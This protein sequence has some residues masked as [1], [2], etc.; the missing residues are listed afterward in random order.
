MRRL[1]QVKPGGPQAYWDAMRRLTAR[2]GSFT[3]RD[4]AERFA[5][6]SENTTACYV[7][8]CVREGY[9]DVVGELPASTP[10]GRPFKRFAVKVTAPLD[11]PFEKFDRRPQLGGGQQQMWTV[12]RA[13]PSFTSRDLAVHASTDEVTI[14]AETARVYCWRLRKAGYLL[15]LGRT[16]RWLVL[17]L[18]PGMNV[19]PK[20]PAI[21]DAGSVVADRNRSARR[22]SAP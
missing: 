1:H 18:K 11:A 19:G 6:R 9:L 4:L 21:I 2:A 10:A 15:E 22:R 16:G 14:S 13:L 12:M 17:R 20:P 7:H 5:D 8:A 3:T